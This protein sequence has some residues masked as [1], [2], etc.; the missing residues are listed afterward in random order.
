M[1]LIRW[2]VLIVRLTM[3]KVKY[4]IDPVTSDDFASWLPLWNANNQGHV[5]QAVTT[6]TWMRLNDPQ[7]HV[8]GLVA[9][10]QD[11]LAGFVHYITHPVTGAI[12]PACYMQDLFVGNDY[13]RQGIAKALVTKLAQIGRKES[14]ARLYWLTEG[15]NEAAQALYKDIGVKLDFTF[16]VMP[17]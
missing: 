3:A 17:L 9:R 11:G 4:T 10:T 8:H 13:R 14:W 15:Q 6:E 12:A 2:I 16:H 5:D 1:V 7:A